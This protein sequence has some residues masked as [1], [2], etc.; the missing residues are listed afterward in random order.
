MIF[1]ALIEALDRHTAALNSNTEI[2]SSGTS[3]AVIVSEFTKYL[4][5]PEDQIQGRGDNVKR[6][7][8]EVGSK[9]IAE[10]PFVN[11]ALALRLLRSLHDYA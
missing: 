2:L 9:T 6:I 1:K 4:S 7:L 3:M 11:H 8:N 5:V 10:I